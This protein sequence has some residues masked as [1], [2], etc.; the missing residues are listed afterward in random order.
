MLFITDYRLICI[1][2]CLV[3]NRLICP[4]EGFGLEYTTL[5]LDIKGKENAGMI[6]SRNVWDI[7]LDSC[8]R[9]H[10]AHTCANEATSTIHTVTGFKR[11]SLMKTDEARSLAFPD[12]KYTTASTLNLHPP[13]VFSHHLKLSLPSLSTLL[14][15]GRWMWTKGP[16]GDW[17]F[18]STVPPGC[19]G[20]FY[21]QSMACQAL[22]QMGKHS[23][24]WYYEH[25]RVACDQWR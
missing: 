18:T 8:L 3:V 21:H 2:V 12:V 11:F 13:L 24:D 10:V 4:C 14:T 23:R 20:A 25:W 5:R 1:P 22:D 16:R 15:R 6:V 17:L 19:H 9:L 7:K